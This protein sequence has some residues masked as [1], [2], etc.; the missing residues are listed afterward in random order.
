MINLN[1][2]DSSLLKINKKLQKDIDL[3]YIGYSTIKKID[4]YENI[5]SV[6]SFVFNISFCYGTFKKKIDKKY[7][8]LDS[9]DKYEE[10]WSGIRSEIKTIN[11]GI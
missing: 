8:I 5:Y 2:F 1:N 3:Y 9:A 7:L 10:V 11:G 4:D 6:K